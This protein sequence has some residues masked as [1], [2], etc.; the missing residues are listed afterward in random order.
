MNQGFIY[1][2]INEAMPGVVKVGRTKGEPISRANQLSSATGV[3]E[4]FSIFRKYEVLDCNEA[5]SFAHRILE[6]VFG[7]PNSKREF[8]S[9]ASTEVA[10]LLDEALQ[11]Y[12][13]RDDSYIQNFSFA[14]PI[15]KLERKEFTSAK[16]EFEEIFKSLPLT[17]ENISTSTSIKKAA[18]AY[19]ACCFAIA[20]TPVFHEIF[21]KNVK[22]EVMTAAIDF[23]K[24][25]ESDPVMPLIEFVRRSEKFA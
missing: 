8:F 13:V 2:L 5:E 20:K 12:L 24:E 9:G 14:S 23:A 1:I 6:R 19:L 4:K 17:K 11:P 3:P 15:L 10:A 7:R 21:S 25:F 22:S 16:L 18:G